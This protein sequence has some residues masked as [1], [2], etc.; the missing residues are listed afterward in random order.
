[1]GA[2]VIAI[3]GGSASGK[4]TLAALLPGALAP[5]STVVIAEDDYYRD[6]RAEPGFVAEAYNF[7][8]PDAR[9]HALLTQHLAA[10]RAGEGVQQPLYDFT[11]HGRRSE[12][13]PIGPCDIVVVEGIHILSSPALLECVDLKVYVD[14]PDDVRLARRL[15]RDVTERA[16]TPAFVV[17][18]YL[19]TVRPMHVRF[20]EPTKWCADLVIA[21]AVESPEDHAPR[22]A[23][24]ARLVADTVRGR[25]A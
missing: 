16:R 7:D 24:Y 15:I 12:S 2:F 10:L 14:T 20:T 18:Q 3:G 19:S 11:V 5:L 25:L 17:Q 23:L 9:D 6:N 22:M 21:D 13:R 1:M 8:H 4:T